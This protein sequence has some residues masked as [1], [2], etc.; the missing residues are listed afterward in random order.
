VICRQPPGYFRIIN[1]NL[2]FIFLP[3]MAIAAVCV[4]IQ[5]HL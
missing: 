5:Q 1:G 4:D 3:A 2:K